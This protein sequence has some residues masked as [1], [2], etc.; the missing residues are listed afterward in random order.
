LLSVPPTPLDF[1]TICLPLLNTPVIQG[2]IIH[3][4]FYLFIYFINFMLYKNTASTYRNGIETMK[5]AIWVIATAYTMLP[6]KCITEPEQHTGSSE[7]D[8]YVHNGVQYY[9]EFCIAESTKEIPESE[10]GHSVGTLMTLC[11][12]SRRP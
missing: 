11:K 8:F 2:E 10:I 5:E 1:L 3:V 6:F 7:C 9:L 12:D 4:S